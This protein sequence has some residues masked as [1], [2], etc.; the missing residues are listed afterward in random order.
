MQIL[1][2]L[3]PDSDFGSDRQPL[4]ILESYLIWAF[5]PTLLRSSQ[6]AFE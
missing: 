5:H 4:G 3:T 6:A 2:A 1:F